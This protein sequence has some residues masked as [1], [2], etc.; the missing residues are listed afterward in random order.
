MKLK[1]EA[2]NIRELVNLQRLLINNAA[3]L[4]KN[5]GVLVYST[6]T[7]EPEENICIIREFLAQHSEFDVDSAAQFVPSSLVTADG[8]VETFPHIHGMDG[9]FSIR[10]KKNR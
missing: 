5:G 2:E 9:S 1:R 7:T 8:Y 4:V 10:L 6:C 3:T